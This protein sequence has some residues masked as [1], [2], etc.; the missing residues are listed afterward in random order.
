QGHA[1]GI[2]R[3]FDLGEP[4]LIPIKGDGGDM[5][6]PSNHALNKAVQQTLAA[7][8]EDDKQPLSAQWREAFE[9]RELTVSD[10]VALLYLGHQRV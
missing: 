8:E 6:E 4:E 9:K 5:L 7:W 1:N 2:V 3:I 10:A